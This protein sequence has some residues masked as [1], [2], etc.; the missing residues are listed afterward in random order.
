MNEHAS[1]PVRV[2][3]TG[4]DLKK[5]SGGIQTHIINFQTA[6]DED[7]A[8]DLQFFPVTFGLHDRESGFAK[9]R[10]LLS[11]FLPFFR[12]CRQVDIVHLNASFDANSLFRDTLLLLI[13]RIAGKKNTIIQFHGGSPAT[14][15]FLKKALV[16]R[17]IGGVLGM[18][19]TRL[20]LS[21][22]QA[23]EFSELYPE[24]DVAVVDNF[25][26]IVA[27]DANKRASRFR[28]IYLGRLHKDKGIREILTAAES[29]LEQGLD[30]EL[31]IYGD[32][33]LKDEVAARVASLNAAN[34]Q[35]H[36]VVRGQDKEAAMELAHCMLLP[37]RHAEGFPYAVLEAFLHRHFL[38][39]SPR[40]ALIELLQ[41]RQ[42]GLEVEADDVARLT[43]HMVWAINN[44]DQVVA[45]GEKAR[46][47]TEKRFSLARLQAVFSPLY[48]AL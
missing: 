6:F 2:L 38:I 9:I 11:L 37:T 15:G 16:R 36:G 18:A 19:K 32:G 5:F 41:E 4:P 34:V 31:G 42:L 7:D 44:Q 29:L 40:G 48:R 24:L 45:A 35:F 46:A 47:L 12:A 10:R 27:T 20:F 3:L 14:V 28:F 30:F 21:K 8:I 23:S 17:W 39:A 43:Q 22:A 26:P 33:P 1:S 13:A 25:L